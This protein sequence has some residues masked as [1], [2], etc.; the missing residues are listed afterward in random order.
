LRA[1]ATARGAELLAD[2]G[3]RADAGTLVGD[4]AQRALLERPP[5]LRGHLSDLEAV[6]SLDADT[7]VPR[8]ADLICT[9]SC[10]DD[11]VRL[12]FHGKTM[13]PAARVLPAPCV[14]A[15]R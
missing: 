9:L 6:R 8:R 14:G 4:A 3:A 15:G 5:A 10:D 7:P 12:G 1:V 13:R 11:R 2:L